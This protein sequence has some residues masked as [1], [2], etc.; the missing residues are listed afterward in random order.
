LATSTQGSI[1]A[2]H[3]EALYVLEILVVCGGFSYGLGVFEVPK[4]VTHN[5]NLLALFFNL[6]SS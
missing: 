2:F 4:K 3:Y 1:E 6:T 5:I